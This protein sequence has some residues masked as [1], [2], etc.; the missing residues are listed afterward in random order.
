MTRGAGQGGQELA[1]L[2][3]HALEPAAAVRPPVASRSWSGS[4]ESSRVGDGNSPS[5]RPRTTTRSRS[6]PTPMEIEPTSTPSPMRPTRPRSASS[7]S[8]MVRVKTSR[9]TDS[10]TASRPASRSRARSTR[11]AAFCSATGQLARRLSPPNRS[12]RCRRAQTTRSPHGRG[13][14]AAPGQVVDQTRGRTPGDAGPGPA[15]ARDRSA[16]HSGA[17]GSASSPRRLGRRGRR[18]ERG[19]PEVPVA[20]SAHHAGIT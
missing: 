6:R 8:S 10:S 9:P 15:S 12:A 7:S 20:T 16:R 5:A 3:F 2:A 18:P 13:R 11:S 4:S 19:Q 1:V 17:S 14:A